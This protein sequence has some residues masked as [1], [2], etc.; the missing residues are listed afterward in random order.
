MKPWWKLSAEEKLKRTE[1]LAI[2]GIV[3]FLILS[4]VSSWIWLVLGIPVV[5]LSYIGTQLHIK[6]QI[7]L[8]KQR[9]APD[10]E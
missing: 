1:W 9:R 6:N 4:I 8:E 10:K 7:E 2:V 5:A 3:L